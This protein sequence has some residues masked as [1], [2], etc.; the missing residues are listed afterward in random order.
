MKR[1]L[2]N[3]D[4]YAIIFGKDPEYIPDENKNW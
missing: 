3:M 1:D 2:N 4:K